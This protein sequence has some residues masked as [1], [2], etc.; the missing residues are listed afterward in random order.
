MPFEDKTAE[1]KKIPLISLKIIV[2]LLLTIENRFDGLCN[3]YDI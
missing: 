2:N 3:D 1:T